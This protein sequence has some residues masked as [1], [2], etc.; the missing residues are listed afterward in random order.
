VSADLEVIAPTPTVAIFKGRDIPISPLKVGQIPAFARAIKPIGGAIGQTGVDVA[1]I[2]LLV[3]DYGENI[4]EAVSIAS[5]VSVDE[6]NDSTADEL[7]G[8]A[9]SV[10]KVNA[11]FFK[12]R[13]TPAILA[14][15]Q[16]HQAQPA[17][18][19]DGQTR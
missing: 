12:G 16:A 10:L 19:G 15:V 3:A 11:D 5:G 2:M 8:L 17:K 1:S 7:V 13:L 9:S 4:V 14:A 6:L 18:G